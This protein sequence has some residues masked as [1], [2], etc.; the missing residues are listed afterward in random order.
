MPEEDM[1]E[2]ETPEEEISDPQGEPVQ[3]E[4]SEVHHPFFIVGCHR[5]G[6]SILRKSLDSHPR[7]SVGKEEPTLYQ[8]AR[9]DNDLCRTRRAG[10]GFSQP[11]WHG[12][13]RHLVE[14]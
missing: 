1:P 3:G 4:P 5:S 10:Y 13:G 2:G 12:L 6:T 14:E 9:T 8:L 11:E 7:I